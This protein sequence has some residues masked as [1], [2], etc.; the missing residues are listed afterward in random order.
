MSDRWYYTHAGQTLGPVTAAQLRQLAG[1]GQL[2]SADLIWPEGKDRTQGV[3]AQAALD[4]ST[5][6]APPAGAPDWLKDVRAAEAKP[7]AVPPAKPDWLD[8]VRQ[9]EEAE[10]EF[11]SIPWDADTVPFDAEEEAAEVL[12][13][14][15]ESQPTT[16]FIPLVPPRPCRLAIGSA[17]TRGRVR[18]L[19][20]DSL[21]VQQ[22]TWGN[23]D[24]RHDVALLVV[25]DGMG[26][27]QA[28]ERASGLVIHTLGGVLAPL[29]SAALGEQ[30]VDPTPEVMAEALDR[31]LQ[32]SNRI[33][34]KAAQDNPACKGMGSTAV[35]LLVWDGHVCIS[36]VGDCRV[37][38]WRAGQLTQITQDQTLV[39]RMVEL[40]QLTPEEAATHPRR[41]EV[42]QAVGKYALLS[43][44]R[45][46]VRLSPGDWLLAGSD[47]LHAH[48]E[49]RT[50]QEAIGKAGASPASLANHLVD[51][52]NKGG[53]SDNC[54]VIA[55]QCS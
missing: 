38:H 6:A 15:S 47:G 18:K 8:D 16:G 7:P 41:N 37:Y 48:V 30:A 12:R 10:Q 39:A 20:E 3:P 11:L 28:G 46:E 43:P 52:A 23:L 5:S 26:G 24:R 34:R 54:T 36:L 1:S 21:L 53:G 49:D 35:A 33:V 50:L 19:N 14:G 27:H 42:S 51:L 17:T 13:E 44:A 25:A 45:Y 2:E 29:V 55:V 9:A 40:G 32:E 31:G 22:C 4:L